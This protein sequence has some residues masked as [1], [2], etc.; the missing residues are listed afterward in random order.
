MTRDAKEEDNWGCGNLVASERDKRDPLEDYC[1]LLDADG[2]GQQY[3][4]SGRK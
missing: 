3:Y 1:G 2:D 4:K